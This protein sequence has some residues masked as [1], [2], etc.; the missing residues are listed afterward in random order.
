MYRTTIYI[1]AWD[2]I[3]YKN[4]VD[5]LR[6]IDIQNPIV[7]INEKT[8]RPISMNKALKSC[9]TEF[10][11]FLESDVRMCNTPFV[12]MS[13]ETFDADKDIGMIVIPGNEVEDFKDIQWDKVPYHC[14][15]DCTLTEAL[16]NVAEWCP[17]L[18]CAFLRISDNF[19][20]DEDYINHQ[21][22]DVD[23]AREI[24]FRGK[25]V[26][27]DGRHYMFYKK[28]FYNEK[29]LLY[30]AMCARNL[31]LLNLKWSRRKNWVS[32]EGFIPSYAEL[33]NMPETKLFEY[34]KKHDEFSYDLWLTNVKKR[35]SVL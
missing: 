15:L 3:E 27:A 5:H 33:L 26:V 21:V 6:S 12:R 35:L 22:F 17:T 23:F 4:C 8:H 13:E 7:R 19:R 25:C 31:H 9:K 10:I 24:D 11:C 32:A 16:K 30:H 28:N 34:M 1:T 18:H 20:F 29:S 2:D 14:K